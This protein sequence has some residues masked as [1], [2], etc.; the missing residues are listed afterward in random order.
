MELLKIIIF[1]FIL[2]IIYCLFIANRIVGGANKEGME[3]YGN[4]KKIN[5]LDRPLDKKKKILLKDLDNMLI[6]VSGKGLKIKEYQVIDLIKG[7]KDEVNKVN[8]GNFPFKLLRDIYN[9]FENINILKLAPKNDKENYLQP[10]SAIPKPSF[11]TNFDDMPPSK[12]AIDSALASLRP[13]PP[14]PAVTPIPPTQSL[15]TQMSL[16]QPPP[17]KP[18]LELSHTAS[19]S[20]LPKVALKIRKDI[21]SH[22]R[23]LEQGLRPEVTSLTRLEKSG[24]V[25]QSSLP[26]APVV[27]LPPTLLPEIQISSRQDQTPSP[28]RPLN[29]QVESISQTSSPESPRLVRTEGTTTITRPIIPPLSTVDSTR[30]ISRTPTSP[31]LT[32]KE[33]EYLLSPTP[34]RPLN[35]SVESRSSKLEEKER[36]SLSPIESSNFVSTPMSPVLS[37]SEHSSEPRRI[38]KPPNLNT[39]ERISTFGP[40]KV[41]EVDYY[42]LDPIKYYLNKIRLVMD[43]KV[44]GKVGKNSDLLSLR[45]NITNRTDLAKESINLLINKINGNIIK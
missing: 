31:T 11:G 19:T 43:N 34:P 36:A 38:P 21:A 15:S 24:L 33:S 44:L 16:R 23:G 18:G 22:Q 40:E 37:L 4:I 8:K 12:D 30:L 20:A 9:L 2:V 25:R 13:S 7:Y 28:P 29:I 35:M 27:T 10:N 42:T 5:T 1:V 32:E 6:Y 26:V 45:K 14:S 3:K 41:Y 39:K 17:V